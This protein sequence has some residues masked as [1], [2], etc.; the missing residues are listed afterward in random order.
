M[1]AHRLGV[2][3]IAPLR[4]PLLPHGFQSAPLS[5]FCLP[6]DLRPPVPRDGFCSSGVHF[7]PRSFLRTRA[8]LSYTLS[9]AGVP[10]AGVKAGGSESIPWGRRLLGDGFPARACGGLGRSSPASITCPM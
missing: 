3:R 10:I 7:R 8:G 9:G 2:Q 1:A 4:V 6:E 5:P